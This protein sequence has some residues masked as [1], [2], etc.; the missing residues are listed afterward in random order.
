MA[1]VDLTAA[2]VATIT[3][4]PATIAA[5]YA[6]KGKRYSKEAAATGGQNKD[7]LDH[8]SNG[9]M[10]EKIRRAVTEVLEERP[11]LVDNAH[12]VKTAVEHMLRRH[13]DDDLA[14]AVQRLLARYLKE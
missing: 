2:Y 1:V 10:D 12:T 14:E 3:A 5:F 7:T 6:A 9:H 11:D 13:S 4:V 8:L